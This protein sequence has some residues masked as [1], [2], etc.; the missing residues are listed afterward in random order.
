MA[1]S[2][3]TSTDLRDIFPVCIFLILGAAWYMAW[4]PRLGLGGDAPIWLALAINATTIVLYVIDKMAA[5]NSR[6]RISENHLHLF[7]IFGGWPGAFLAQQACRHKIKDRAF[8]RRFWGSA[9]IN[10][11]MFFIV[12]IAPRSFDSLFHLHPRLF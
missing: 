11:G 3:S 2:P 1:V 5:I 8:Q 10:V 4:S 7:S 12:S 9:V 6:Q